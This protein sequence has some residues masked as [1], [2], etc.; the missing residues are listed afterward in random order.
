MKAPKI[1]ALI[2]GLG[3]IGQLYDMDKPN[4]TATHA[5]A[6]S[7]HPAYELVAGIDPDLKKRS[8]FKRFYKKP[9]YASAEIAKNLESVD[10][11]SICV[12]TPLHL[13]AVKSALKFKPKVILCEKPIASTLREARKIIRLCHQGKC[14]LSINYMRRF[15]PGVRNLKQLIDAKQCGEIRKGVIWYGNG[16]L[17]NASH[18]INLLQFL[19]GKAKGF[20]ILKKGSS[21]KNSDPDFVIRFGQAEIYFL[22]FEQNLYT[23][24]H[25][26]LWGTKGKISYLNRGAEIYFQMAGKDPRFINHI[27]LKDKKNY[28]KND[29]YYYQWHVLDSLR[30]SLQGK[31]KRSLSDA[32]SAVETLAFV[33]RMMQKVKT[34]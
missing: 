1:K 25:M 7:Q 15:E 28:I 12:P 19:I 20:S 8:L 10:I 23:T 5:K 30:L 31:K 11:V 6:Y 26:E 32:K 21:K 22:A 3:N 34:K 33:E 24:L 2:M 29:Y 27:I 18:Y 14:H 17:N 13:S 9:A 4:M 16:L